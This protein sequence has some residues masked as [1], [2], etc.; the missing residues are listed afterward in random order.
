MKTLR[1]WIARVSGLFGRSRRERELADEIESHLQLHTDD[2]IRRGMTPALARR[3][4][5]LE[6]GSPEA[7]KEEYRDQRGIPLADYVLQDLKYAGRA[8]RRDPGFTALAVLTIAFGVAGPVVMFTMAKAWILDPLPFSNPNSLIDLRRLEMPSGAVGGLNRADFLDFKRTTRTVGELA[9]YGETEVRITGG[10]R[11]ERLRGAAVSA[12]FFDLIGVRAGR[13]R[14][15][16]KGE[17]Q[18][19]AP[20]VTVISDALWR[21]RFRGDP[22]IEGHTIRLDD[23]DCTIVGVMPPDFQFTLLGRVEVWQPLV[24]AP[25][26]ATNRSRGW[27]RAIG[28]LA[29]GRTVDQG[30]DE[31]TR[32]ASDLAVAHPDTNKNRSVRVLRL[33]DEVRQH[34]DMGFIVPVLFA[35]VGCVLLIACVNVTNVMLA[36][37]S[38]RRREMAVRLALG[39]SRARIVQQWLV[40]HVLLFV[41]ASLLGAGLAVYGTDWITNS[42]PL[43]NRQYLRNFATLTV[44]PGSLAFALS[45]GAL[46]GVI[47]GCIPAWTGARVNVN[48]D[49]RDSSGRTTMSR[50]MARLRSTL[51]VAEVALALALLISAGL[52]VQTAQNLTKAD[53]GFEPARLLTFRLVLDEKRYSHPAAVRGFYERLADDL[54]GRA[55]VVGAAAGSLVPFSGIDLS[56][57][58]LVVGQPEPKPSDTPWTAINQVTPTYG[59]VIGLRVR[60]G[61]FLTASDGPDAQKV[62]VVNETLAARH[63]PGRDPIGERLRLGRDSKDVWTIVGVVG[64]V[65]NYEPNDRPE[66]QV[67][68]SIA[69]RPRRFMTV[70]VRSSGDPDELSATVRAAVSALDP[71]EPV[72][73]VFT[74]ERMITFVTGP[75]R[76]ISTFVTFFGVLTLLLSA[77]GVYGVIAYTFAQRTREIGIRMAL[78]ARR[79]DVAALVMK[80]L[81]LF[82][83]AAMLPGVALA[84][85]LGHALRSMLVGVTPTEAWIYLA[86]S[87]VLAGVAALAALVPARRATTIDPMTALRYE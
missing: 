25:D 43:E 18:D 72:S 71:A 17:D 41:A 67:Y 68:V 60:Q 37:A 24:F 51:V 49:L 55:G 35:M 44:G 3:Q 50:G 78:G 27:V 13:G 80:Q 62:I 59:A 14:V 32:I 83:L 74:M 82:L 6:L 21:D 64:D 70:I 33:A 77:V 58:L 54:A 29:P 16:R 81:R 42:I 30:R 9:G 69:Q 66:P 22:S 34:H 38:T 4:A 73:R 11:A 12:N 53:L 85:A 23:R 2:N 52:L 5:V 46:C 7:L 79:L 86:M 1:R 28:R 76:T 84:W 36:R 47:F 19:G 56:T 87:A 61:R 65:K 26:D 57:E 48:D 63:F 8:L 75:Y 40:E 20:C 39:A 10:D 31:L 45:V 15:F